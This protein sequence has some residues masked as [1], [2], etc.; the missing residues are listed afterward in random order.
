LKTLGLTGGVGMGKST[1]ARYLADLGVPVVDTDLLARQVVAPGE[2]A[3]AEVKARFGQEIIGADGSLRREELARRVFAD[4]SARRDLEAILHP[5]IRERWLAQVESWRKDHLRLGVVV[6]PLLFETNVAGHFDATVCVACLP[7]TQRARLEARGW[8]PA[9][10]QQR[11]EAQL[12]V[13]KKM[14]LADFVIWSEGNL[15]VHA[16]Q[17][18]F[19]L[20]EIG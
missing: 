9:Q 15:E 4:P 16:Q 7:R 5:R 3:L 2:P 19:L 20:R 13:E 17:L 10:I 8:D 1:S 11:I 6:I 12:P 18:R 14:A